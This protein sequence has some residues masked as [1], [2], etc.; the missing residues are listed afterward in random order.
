MINCLITKFL[1]T[2]INPTWRQNAAQYDNSLLGNFGV[3]SFMQS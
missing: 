1:M 2:Q 3:F